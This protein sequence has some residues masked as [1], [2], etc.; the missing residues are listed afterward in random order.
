MGETRL[1]TLKVNELSLVDA[2][3]V[4]KAKFLIAKR[5]TPE[6]EVT[7]ES[8]EK[9]VAPQGYTSSSAGATSPAHVH[10]YSLWLDVEDGVVRVRGWVDECCD[11]THRFTL[12]GYLKGEL[13]ASD[14]HTHTLMTI[15]EA[16]AVFAHGRPPVPESD[17]VLTPEEAGRL[18]G[19]LAGIGVGV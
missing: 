7:L 1:T 5:Q 18:A 11:H 14:G 19:I 12:E 9:R 4:P 15:K 16:R 6:P 10:D 13:E 3:A 2:P 17:D 8:V